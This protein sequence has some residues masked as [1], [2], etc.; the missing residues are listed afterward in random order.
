MAKNITSATDTDFTNDA[1]PNSAVFVKVTGTWGGT[2]L[3]VKV[4]NGNGEWETYPTNGTQTAD[5]AYYYTLGD[6]GSIRL[7]TTG[8]TGID[9][10]AQVVDSIQ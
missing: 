3:D 5:F 1:R 2:S 6:E 10:W 8:G 4:K 7:T 9:L